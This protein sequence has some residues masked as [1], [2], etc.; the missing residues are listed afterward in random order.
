MS[1]Y[2]GMMMLPGIAGRWDHDENGGGGGR[3]WGRNRGWGLRPQK[4]TQH[5]FFENGVVG[6]MCRG[7][8]KPPSLRRREIGR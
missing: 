5:P 7:Y 6:T 8:D 3:D 1:F 2:A 4:Q